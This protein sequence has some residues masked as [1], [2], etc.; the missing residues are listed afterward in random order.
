ME[1]YIEMSVAKR[2]TFKDRIIS[3]FV[4][5]L[6]MFIGIYIVILVTLSKSTLLLPI[7]VVI[8]ALLCWFSYKIYCNFNIDWEYTLVGDELRFAKIINKSKRR[9]V[10]SVSIPKSTVIARVDDSAHNNKIRSDC[11][12]YSFI[13]QTNTRFYFITS[14]DEKGNPVCVF[15]EPDER[16]LDN[17]AVT[18]RGKFYL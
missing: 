8:C 4:S 6:P 11:K 7:A 5:I 15:F 17:F 1:S 10:I 3:F 18:A 9:E 12:K 16:M 2:P 14:F 13:S